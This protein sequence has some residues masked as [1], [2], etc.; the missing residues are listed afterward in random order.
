MKELQLPRQVQTKW[1]DNL[2][3]LVSNKHTVTFCAYRSPRYLPGRGEEGTAN[4][5]VTWYGRGTS[6]PKGHETE[7]T[8]R[9]PTH[10]TGDVSAPE[11]QIRRCCCL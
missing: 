2:M 3:K 8:R 4:A 7:G 11:L 6:S 5:K 1:K 10:N 9:T